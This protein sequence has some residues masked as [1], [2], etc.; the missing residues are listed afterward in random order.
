MMTTTLTKH[1][2]LK[3]YHYSDGD[4]EPIW[5]FIASQPAHSA[6]GARP[7]IIKALKQNWCNDMD[8]G[9]VSNS[10]WSTAS[11]TLSSSLEKLALYDVSYSFKVTNG[12]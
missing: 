3:N 4:Y 12:G 2:D 7:S 1:Y 9:Y 10:V 6:S 8:W 5:Y 11:V